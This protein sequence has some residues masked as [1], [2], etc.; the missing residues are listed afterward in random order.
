MWIVY[1]VLVFVLLV[2]TT[3]LAKRL[4][5][6][7]AFIYV[8]LLLL[9]CISGDWLLRN[10]EFED[11][12]TATEASEAPLH[13]WN[14]EIHQILDRGVDSYESETVWLEVMRQTARERHHNLLVAT[15]DVEQVRVAPWHFSITRAQQSYERHGQAWSEHLGEWTAFVGPDLPTADGEIKASFDIA[16]NGFLDALTL[17]PQFDLRSRVEDIFRE[18]VLRLVTTYET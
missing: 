11:L 5:R 12:V 17:F 10:L 15:N 16:E 14:R 9:A 2:G 13:R 7:W 6:L 4:R 8:P 1:L 3:A 18:R